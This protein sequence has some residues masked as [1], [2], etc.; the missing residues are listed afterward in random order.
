[1]MGFNQGHSRPGMFG[2]VVHYD[3]RGRE[4]GHSEPGRFG[5]WHHYED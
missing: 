2:S 4:V 3:E 1:M 5:N